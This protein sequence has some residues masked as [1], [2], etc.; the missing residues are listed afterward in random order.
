MLSLLGL[1]KRSN[2]DYEIDHCNSRNSVLIDAF[3][4]MAID[5]AKK[6]ASRYKPSKAELSI[7]E[8]AFKKE[9]NN[10]FGYAIHDVAK[11]KAQELAT[12][13]GEKIKVNVDKILDE[14]FK[15]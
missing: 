11:T 15:K 9:V 12:E 5:E 4:S 14:E 8:A 13:A 7:Y 6:I 3:R 10:Q 2:Y 1:E